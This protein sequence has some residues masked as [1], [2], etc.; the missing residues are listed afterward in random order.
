M[1]DFIRL[2]YRIVNL[3][4]IREIQF[5]DDSVVIHWQGNSVSA[6]T[7]FDAVVFLDILEQRYTLM[8]DSA[9]RLWKEEITSEASPG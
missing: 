3:S 1:P 7:G 2:P 4:L 9:A 8:T 5:S 6:L